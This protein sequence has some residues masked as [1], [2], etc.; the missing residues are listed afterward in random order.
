MTAPSVVNIGYVTDMQV[1]DPDIFYEIEGNS[2]V[3]N[4]YEG[5]VQYG[6]NTTKVVPSLA[7]SWTV[8]PD[9][10]TYSFKLHPGVAFHDGS[11]TMTSADVEA[12]F[13]RRSHLSSVPFSHNS[14]AA[15]TPELKACSAAHKASVAVVGRTTSKRPRSI[16][17]CAKAGA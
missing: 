13:K 4:V 9:G 17:C 1:P 10:L 16:P 8:S 5:L 7:D 15:Q 12:S 3:T 11:G 6:N 2:V 14:T